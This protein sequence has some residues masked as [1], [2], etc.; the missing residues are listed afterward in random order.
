VTRGPVDE[1]LDFSDRVQASQDDQKP[2]KVSAVKVDGLELAAGVN[3][4]SGNEVKI[5]YTLESSIQN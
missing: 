4:K 2:A 5:S 1:K 3:M